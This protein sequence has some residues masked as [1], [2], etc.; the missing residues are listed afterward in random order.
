MTYLGQ[1]SYE[2]PFLVSQPLVIPLP[3]KDDSP[4]ESARFVQ[5]GG[6]PHG[7]VVTTSKQD[8]L[9]FAGLLEGTD[10]PGLYEIRTEPPSAPIYLAV[11]V[12]PRE[13]HVQALDQA[14]LSEV[15]GGLKVRVVGAADHV[16]AAIQENRVGKQLWKELLAAALMVLLIEGLLALYFT[17]GKLI[18]RAAEENS[19]SPDRGSPIARASAFAPVPAE[20]H[21]GTGS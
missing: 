8:G 11:N 5:L 15:F 1:R 2:Q 3:L 20:A 7:K 12:D 21:A 17:R 10:R 18:A 13:S 4:V 14:A 6:D 9:M 16:E 19:P